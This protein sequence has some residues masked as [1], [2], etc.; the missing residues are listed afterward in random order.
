[1]RLENYIGDLLYRYQCVTIPD[2]GSFLTKNQ[3]A[4][5]DKETNTFYPP[6][7]QLSFNSQLR[8]NDGL[9]AKYISEVEGLSYEDVLIQLQ[10]VVVLWKKSLDNKEK[11]NLKNIG[12]LSL[13]SDEKFV[14]E[15]ENQVNYLTSSFGLTSMVTPSI[16]REVLKLEVESIEEKTPIA[17][18]PERRESKS[19]LKYAAIFLLALSTGTVGYKL[20]NTKSQNNFQVAEKEVQQQVEKQIQEA[21]FFDASPIEMPSITLDLVKEPLKYHIV[22]GA[23]RVEENA[24]KRIKELNDKGYDAEKIGVNKYGLHQVAYASFAKVEE[25][26]QFLRKIKATE[27]SEA[28]LLVA[29]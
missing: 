22:A 29:E 13:S 24:D 16:T 20:I 15:P 14:F 23:F 21:T 4:R 2:F 3:S 27:S 5:I 26:L 12:D 7:K 11:I 19:Y 17:F 9:L 8:S 25:A 6:T 1:M 10:Q 28:W 18:T